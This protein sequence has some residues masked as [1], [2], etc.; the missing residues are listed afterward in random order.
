MYG[1]AYPL[2]LILVPTLKHSIHN[3]N[4]SD[5]FSD[6]ASGIYISYFVIYVICK[7]YF[8]MLLM[9]LILEQL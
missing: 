8:F 7:V 6:D 5:G 3:V 1:T 9:V 4:F 2:M